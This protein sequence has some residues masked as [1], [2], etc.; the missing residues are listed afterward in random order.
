MS[1]ERKARS[2]GFLNAI[3]SE[4]NVEALKELIF[5]THEKNDGS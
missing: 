5:R 4:G 3:S 2:V 1:T